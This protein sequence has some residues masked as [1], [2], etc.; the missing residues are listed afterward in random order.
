MASMSGAQARRQY[1][2]FTT[3]RPARIEAQIVVESV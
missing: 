1:R 2:N 3:D